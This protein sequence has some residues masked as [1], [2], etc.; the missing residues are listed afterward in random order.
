MHRVDIE[1]SERG[2]G[3]I[4]NGSRIPPSGCA[5]CC[6]CAM[7]EL[8][9][10]SVTNHACDDLQP[11]V[12]HRDAFVAVVDPSLRRSK[13]YASPTDTHPP[14]GKNGPDSGNCRYS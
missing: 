2:I 9:P 4:Y 3:A 7:S 6:Y 14:H 10:I 8:M 11:D 12:E 13:C 5:L 1:A